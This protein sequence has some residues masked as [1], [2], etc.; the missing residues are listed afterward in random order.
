M[1]TDNPDRQR[2]SPV[3]KTASG[4]VI[5]SRQG[6][7]TLCLSKPHGVRRHENEHFRSACCRRRSPIRPRQVDPAPVHT[8]GATVVEGTTEAQR[9]DRVH[10]AVGTPRKN[11]EFLKW[12]GGR[13]TDTGR[14]DSEGMSVAFDSCGLQ[15]PSNAST[16]KNVESELR[17]ASGVMS[18]FPRVQKSS[19]PGSGLARTTFTQAIQT[20]AAPRRNCDRKPGLT[21]VRKVLF[22]ADHPP[23]AEALGPSRRVAKTLRGQ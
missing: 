12:I 14:V 1:L 20:T 13:S 15:S 7:R 2:S 16:L 11:R 3:P 8:D 22:E 10:G 5:P 18:R 6:L 21:P 19:I 9:Q 17:F 4:I 23:F